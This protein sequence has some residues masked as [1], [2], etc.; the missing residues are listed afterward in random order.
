[1]SGGDSGEIR[2]VFYN[3]YREWGIH[4]LMPKP[5]KPQH[6]RSKHEC[7]RWSLSCKRNIITC[8]ENMTVVSLYCPDCDT[9][10]L[11][12]WQL[13]LLNCSPSAT[14]TW[15]AGLK[16]ITGNNLQSSVLQSVKWPSGSNL[17]LM[18]GLLRIWGKIPCWLSQNQTVNLI[19][20]AWVPGSGLSWE[21]DGSE[22]AGKVM[23]VRKLG[24]WG[25]GVAPYLNYAVA[26]T[27]WLSNSQFSRWSLV[28]RQPLPLPLLSSYQWH[29]DH[30]QHHSYRRLTTL[31]RTSLEV[32]LLLFIFSAV[33]GLKWLSVNT[34]QEP[35]S[36]CPQSVHGIM[37]AKSSLM[38]PACPINYW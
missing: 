3:L 14:I 12:L 13:T 27:N 28:E 18:T 26:D 1:M 2:G 10:I 8:R 4:Q 29:Y 30:C 24:R 6:D 16:G 7:D 38:R 15:V 36:L 23:A 17:Q 20:L 33:F 11:G 19:S 22:E 32:T 9:S 5:N 35:H 25:R 37:T 31:S 21:G 34:C